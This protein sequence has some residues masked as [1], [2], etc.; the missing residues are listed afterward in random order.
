M[1]RSPFPRPRTRLRNLDAVDSSNQSPFQGLLR[2]SPRS[3]A[4]QKRPKQ[5]FSA[6][7]DSIDHSDL[8]ER[9]LAHL[10]EH[11]SQAV[12]FASLLYHQTFS[13]EDALLLAKAQYFDENFVG[14]LRTLDTSQASQTD[15]PWEAL[16]LGCQALS[17]L[18]DWSTMEEIISNACSN[19]GEP[20]PDDG[21]WQSLKSSIRHEGKSCHPLAR[22]LWWR[23]KAHVELGDPPR[24]ARFWKIALQLDPTMQTAHQS[25]L[26][27]HLLTPKEVH[28]LVGGID[29]PE[30]L[31]YIYLAQI[32]SPTAT[33]VEN[34]PDTSFGHLDASSIQLSTP[35]NMNTKE[36]HGIHEDI[37]EAFTKVWKSYKLQHAPLVLSVAADRAYRRGDWTTAL[38]HCQELNDQ[39]GYTH[40]ATLVILGKTRELFSL[41]HSWV[42]SNPQNALAW[43]AVG[44]YYYACGRFHVAQRHFCKATRLDPTSVYS[45]IA[46]GCSFGACDESDQ[47]L[48]SFRAAQRLSPGEHVALL[49]MGMEYVRTN[50]KVLANYFLQAALTT[51]SGGDALVLHELGTL[52]FTQGEYTT[53]IDWYNKALQAIHGSNVSIAEC[54]ATLPDAYWEPTLFN[55]GHALRKTHQFD[56]AEECFAACVRLGPSGSTFSAYGFTLHL[57]GKVDEAIVAYHEALGFKPDDTL[58]TTLLQRALEEA[59]NQLS[60]ASSQIPPP[61]EHKLLSPKPSLS[62]WTDNSMMSESSD[63][64]VSMG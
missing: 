9:A 29:P 3:P 39:G 50:H 59:L 49:Y 10:T 7:D 2:F 17:K 4:S 35:V 62:A 37:D 43:F 13:V 23:G 31:K 63:V 27:H 33:V 28:E 61:E 36:K 24:A 54:C 34:T 21:D 15:S 19:G 12:F 42:E 22:L 30:W 52:A 46:F 41:A 1:S 8:R 11:P 55:L 38:K 18:T 16:L 32:T 6:D 53:A 57:Q 51:S 14:C 40:V 25:L 5:F 48:A 58:V 44:A 45:W 26:E 20:L 47:A 60:V 64:D 56:M